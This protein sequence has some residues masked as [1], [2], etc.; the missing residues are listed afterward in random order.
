MK[1]VILVL[2]MLIASVTGLNAQQRTFCDKYFVSSLGQ[3]LPYKVIYPDNFDPT[4]SYPMLLFLHG[5]GERGTDNNAQIV[6]GGNLLLTDEILTQAIVIAPQC[7]NED[8]WIRYA[9]LGPNGFDNF[10]EN[11]PISPS[12]KAVKEL[13]D[14]FISLGFVDTDRIY[15]TGLS[16][17]GMGTFDLVLRY[18]DFFAAVAPIC[19]GVNID[20]VKAYTGHTAFRFFHGLKDNVVPP[21]ANQ[22]AYEELKAKGLHVDYVAY[23][24][25]GHNS[26]DDA[27][28]EPDFI[29]WLF[30]H[31]KID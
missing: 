25:D 9:D 18:P 31:K 13:L 5:A 7:P 10:A 29:S 8:F 15:G 12:L 30:D 22:A 21:A 2:A 14:C 1:K 19:G 28:A 23:P 24:E 11:A 3:L 16:M 17:G 4:A 26:W 20:R 6:H 27:F